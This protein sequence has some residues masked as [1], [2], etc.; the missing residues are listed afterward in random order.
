M[1]CIVLSRAIRSPVKYY[2][3]LLSNSQ[4]NLKLED[5]SVLCFRNFTSGSRMD[6][7]DEKCN[8]ASENETDRAK[9]KLSEEEWKRKLTPEQYYV[10]RQKGTEPPFTG[11]YNHHCEEGTYT[12]VCCGVELFSSDTKYDSGCG[13]PAFHTAHGAKSGDESQAN[14]VRKPDNSLGRKR[15]E[16][17]CKQCNAHL[18]HV[19]KDG[20]QPTGERFC[21]NSV[22]LN[23]KSKK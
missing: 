1:N 12:C 14:V 23:F 16:V 7:K 22:A 15:T 9:I 20:P 5:K 11:E 8:Q 2:T 18:G 3:R 17:L 6:S 10:C 13:W 19:F 21:I 4:K